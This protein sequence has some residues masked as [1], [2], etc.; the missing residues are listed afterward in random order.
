MQPFNSNGISDSTVKEEDEKLPKFNNHLT[1]SRFLIPGADLGS[2]KGGVQSC[3]NPPLN[4]AEKIILWLLIPYSFK[5]KI[6]FPYS[7]TVAAQSQRGHNVVTAQSH[8]SRSAVTS[9]SHRS[10]IAVAAFGVQES[11]Q[12]ES[13]DSLAIALCWYYKDLRWTALVLCSKCF[14]IAGFNCTLSCDGLRG[15][16]CYMETRL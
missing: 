5:I 10:R 4:T 3:L 1:D 12:L 13:C 9:Q 14:H 11:I 16:R 8:H 15:L 6:W 7:I 2:N